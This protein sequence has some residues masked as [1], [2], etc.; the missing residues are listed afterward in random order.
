MS[1][2]Q[3]EQRTIPFFP[4]NQRI[5]LY[6]SSSKNDM[7]VIKMNMAGVAGDQIMGSQGEIG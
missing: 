3:N 1:P 6:R 7:I 2:M 5:D 4:L